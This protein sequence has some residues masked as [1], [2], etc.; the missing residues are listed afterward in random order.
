[1]TRIDWW[2][3][4]GLDLAIDLA[5]SAPDLDR[6]DLLLDPILQAGWRRRSGAPDEATADR[7]V[8]LRDSIRAV[9]VPVASGV[10]LAD[11]GLARGIAG[12]NRLAASAPTVP[13]IEDGELVYVARASPPDAFAAEVAAAALETA[14]GRRGRLRACARTGCGRLFV[15]TR[16]RR[17]WCGDRCGTRARVARH[18]QTIDAPAR[19]AT[20]TG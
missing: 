13:Q 2:T 15:T 3:A 10:A 12:L 8:D 14:A 1:M 16:A 5:N 20:Q 7:L 19:R 4:V 17:T 9:L 6:P 18:R 11:P